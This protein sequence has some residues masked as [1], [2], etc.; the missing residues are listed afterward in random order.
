MLTEIG[1]KIQ[2]T[3]NLADFQ[4]QLA[5]MKKIGSLSDIMGMLPYGNKLGKVKLEERQLIWTAAIIKSMPRSER[6]N[7]DIINGSRR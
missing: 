7:P 3:F 4:K 2:H 5:Q 1:R 6:E